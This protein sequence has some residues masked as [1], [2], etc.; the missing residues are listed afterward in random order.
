MKMTDELDTPKT[1]REVWTW[2]DS[3]HRDTAGKDFPAVSTYFADGM[4][5][6]AHILGARIVTNS[7]G[8]YS[9]KRG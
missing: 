7:D 6:A 8:S 5:E 1:L 3:V 9:F 4:K 2:K